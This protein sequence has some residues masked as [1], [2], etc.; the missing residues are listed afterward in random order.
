M[1]TIGRTLVTNPR[2]LL[3]DEPSE[4]LAQLIVAALREQISAL[5]RSGLTILLAEQ[6]VSFSLSLSDRLY[7]LEKG[8]VR[9]SGSPAAFSADPSIQEKYLF[10]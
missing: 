2:L 3:L 7:V 10:V 9:F 8:E 4:G 1:L 5:K 6:S